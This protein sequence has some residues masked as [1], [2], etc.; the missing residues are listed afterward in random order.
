MLAETRGPGGW[1]SCWWVR[2]QNST[3][4]SWG[5]HH[6]GGNTPGQCSANTSRYRRNH[7]YLWGPAE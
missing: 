3:A 4:I 1:D 6:S 7:W 5:R 2:R